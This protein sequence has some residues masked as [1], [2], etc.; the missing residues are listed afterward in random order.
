LFFIHRRWIEKLVVHRTCTW[1]GR[2]RTS[3]T[4]KPCS[5]MR[6]EV[7]CRES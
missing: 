1:Y 3:L 2:R 6:S 5:A 4:S 7:Q